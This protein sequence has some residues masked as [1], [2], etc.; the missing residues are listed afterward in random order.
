MEKD[1]S[2]FIVVSNELLFD[3]LLKAGFARIY[4]DGGGPKL[5]PCP[6]GTF[7]DISDTRPSCKVCPAGKL[8]QMLCTKV[9]H[10]YIHE[11]KTK[12]R[13][14]VRELCLKCTNLILKFIKLSSQT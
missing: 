14:I 10:S 9:V 13:F 7:V 11:L 6:P 1:D 12:N 3:A 5:L 8:T 2:E 4:A